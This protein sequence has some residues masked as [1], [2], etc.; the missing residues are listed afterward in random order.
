MNTSPIPKSPDH[1]L[2]YLNATALKAL[3]CEDRFNW[4]CVNGWRDRVEN[5]IFSVGKAIHKF[6]E[7]MAKGTDELEALTAATS[8][9][10]ITDKTAV[11]KACG[12]YRAAGMSPAAIINAET[13]VEYRFAIPFAEEIRDG[14]TYEV[15]LTGR[16][17]RIAHTR[18]GVEIT[19][20]KSTRKWDFNDVVKNYADDVQ[21]L[22]YYTVARRFAYDIF[23]GDMA[24]ANDAWNGKLFTRLCAVMLSKKPQPQ[25][26]L[27][28]LWSPNEELWT[29]F[30]DGL[31]TRIVPHVVD[32]YARKRVMRR[33]GLY[34]NLCPGCN[35]ADLCLRERPEGYVREEYLPLTW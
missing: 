10:G 2:I 34:K 26:I 20:Y 16:F 13:L 32:L 27:G 3:A 17:D 22:F 14:L 24:M 12:G 23:N 6:G 1:R 8:T 33:E 30:L 28:P 7:E 21:F 9:P 18:L 29:S 31:K 4:M 15:Y 5:P 11:V 19:D 25:W 35:F